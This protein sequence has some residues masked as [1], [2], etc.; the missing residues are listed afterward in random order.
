MKPSSYCSVAYLSSLMKLKQQRI[1]WVDLRIKVVE[2]KYNETNMHIKGQF[3]NR[4]NDNVM[5]V[6]I[7]KE[8]MAIS[9]KSSVTS[10]H[11]LACNRRVEAQRS[12]MAILKSLKNNKEF[13]AT[14][15]QRNYAKQRTQMQ[16]Q[17]T[18]QKQKPYNSYKQQQHQIPTH[19][20]N[21]VHIV[22]HTS[23]NTMS[24]TQQDMQRK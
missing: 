16:N 6:E 19:S 20:S 5:P 2:C 13:D 7:I 23:P 1:G 3:I 22:V 14:N 10:S 9:D 21:D 12:K 15:T 4:L 24:S 17:T 18:P 11:V 8:F